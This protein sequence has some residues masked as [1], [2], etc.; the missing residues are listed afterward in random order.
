MDQS[1]SLFPKHLS[2]P[3]TEISIEGPTPS[4]WVIGEKIGE[5]VS[6]CTE[7]DLEDG[8]GPSYA[9]ANFTCQNVDHPDR[10]GFMRIFLQIPDAGSELDT[11]EERA[12]QASYIAHRE[13]EALNAFTEKGSQITPT[14]L[15]SE[16]RRQ[17]DGD[18]VPGGY[19]TILV[20]NVLPGIRLGDNLGPDTFWALSLAERE[21]I[22][23]AF[24]PAY[25]YATRILLSFHQR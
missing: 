22:R 3:G 21:A 11:P 20:W 17:A 15:A 19:I 9:D 24:E 5:H 16:E 10:R 1:R 25:K 14:L 18:P 4:T 7:V 6:Q 2:R 12:R 8:L 13:L 23:K